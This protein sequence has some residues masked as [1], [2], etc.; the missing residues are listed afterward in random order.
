MSSGAPSRERRGPSCIMGTA[1]ARRQARPQILAAFGLFRVGPAVPAR[2]DDPRSTT[3]DALAALLLPAKKPG[4][5]QDSRAVPV[6]LGLDPQTPW[7]VANLPP[8]PNQTEAG[9]AA[10]V[11]R[12][13]VS[14]AVLKARDRWR[15]DLRLT[16]LRTDL[17]EIV[18][19]QSG[20]VTADELA[21]LLLAVRGS[22]QEEPLRSTCAR[23]SAGSNRATGWARMASSSWRSPI[24]R[25]ARAG[26]SLSI[27]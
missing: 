16:A 23:A 5:K 10:G 20:A 25:P 1:H 24:A 2:P 12:A 8:W 26:A 13:R 27:R 22:Q 19:K 11:T 9:K 18:T 7:G 15:R 21:T 14:Q 17:A 3:V 4:A 6:W